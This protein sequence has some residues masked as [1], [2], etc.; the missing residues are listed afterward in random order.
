MTWFLGL[1]VASFL[2]GIVVLFELD[3][4][5]RGGA[6]GGAGGRVPSM[7]PRSLDLGMRGAVALHPM[8]VAGSPF[9]PDDF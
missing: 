4:I 7:A 8:V 1:L 5:G 9:S 2:G 6:K 3:E